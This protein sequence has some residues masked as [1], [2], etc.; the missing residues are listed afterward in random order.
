MWKKD[1][2]LVTSIFSFLTTISVDRKKKKTLRFIVTL[3]L[4]SANAFNLEYSKVILYGK[5]LTKRISKSSAANS[6]REITDKPHTKQS[7]FFTK[8]VIWI[9]RLSYGKTLIDT[10]LCNDIITISTNESLFVSV[11]IS[12]FVVSN[13]FLYGLLLESY[14]A[15]W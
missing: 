15:P 8:E 9:Q 1:K 13:P 7:S 10:Y 12:N 5:R 4:T 2:M 3:I 6:Q 11:C 14:V